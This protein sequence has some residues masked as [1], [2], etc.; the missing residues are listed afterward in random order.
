MLGG[1][2]AAAH[3]VYQEAGLGTASPL[4][5]PGLVGHTHACLDVCGVCVPA[6]ACVRAHSDS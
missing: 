1:G 2:A 5:P 3:Q 4:S 6:C